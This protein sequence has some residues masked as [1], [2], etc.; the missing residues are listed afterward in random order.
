VRGHRIVNPV[1]PAQP[2]PASALIGRRRSLATRLSAV[3]RRPVLAAFA[4]AIVVRSVVAVVITIGWGGSLF[5]DD[6]TYSRIAQA[7][8]DGRLSSLGPYPE[9]LYERTGTLLVPITGL[10]EVLGPV[11]L[12]GQLYVALLGAVTAALTTR[13]ALEVVDRRFAL[14]AGLLVALLPSQ[15]L[16][17][18][19]IMKD[20]A[21]WACL[22]ALAIVVA[23][24]ADSAGRKLALL[25]VAALALLVLLGFLR[26]QT[27][28]VACVA[29]VLA[30]IV[31]DACQRR[32]RVVV[33]VAF[34]ICVPLAFGMGV[35]GASYV[36]H[37]QD[38]G[39]QRALNA[40]GARSAIDEATADT[41]VVR[42]LSY[43][44]KGLTVVGLRPWPWES[45]GGS[46][47]VQLARAETLVWYPL[48]V[49]AFVGL[50]G[51]WRRRRALAFPVL[52]AGAVLVMYGVTEGN[53]GTAY[54]HRG[55]LVW[56]IVLLATLGLER[57]VR[58]RQASTRAGAFAAPT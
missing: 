53:L 43:L 37:A 50:G 54:R 56:A 31:S 49:L 20:A 58:G 3:E 18:S 5:L 11:E 13:L 7:A 48:V 15:V 10:Y 57:L 35:A 29:L 8:A 4:V 51:V 33:A 30:T 44:P 32:L 28:E 2:R 34:L 26:L 22:S 6:T 40:Q 42:Q 23:I 39:W 9:W 55:E 1:T 17:S 21:V 46:L 24:A 38:P 16:W 52:T 12:A 36:A 41:G 47:G 27:L 25:G 14:L 45:A 19:I